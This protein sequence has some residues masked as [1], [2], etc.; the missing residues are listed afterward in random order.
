MEIMGEYCYPHT[1]TYEW[2]ECQNVVI[3]NVENGK[4]NRLI[5]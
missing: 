3:L 5:L 1:V 2:N 4:V